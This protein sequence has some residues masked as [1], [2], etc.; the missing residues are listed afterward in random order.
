MIPITAGNDFILVTEII[1]DIGW[2]GAGGVDFWASSLML[3]RDIGYVVSNLDQ[4]LKPVIGLNHDA[5]VGFR[6]VM[7]KADY[8]LETEIFAELGSDLHSLVID[9]VV[10][11]EPNEGGSAIISGEE[12]HADQGPESSIRVIIAHEHGYLEFDVHSNSVEH[13]A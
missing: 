8:I 3:G 9:R 5:L 13:I 1:K 2:V 4:F 11:I 12:F 10:P 7:L 6:N